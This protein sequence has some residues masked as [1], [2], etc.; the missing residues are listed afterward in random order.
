MA[1][2]SRARRGAGTRSGSTSGVQ[3]VGLAALRKEL[4]KLEDPRTWSKALAA[5]HREVAQDVAAEARSN[6]SSMGGAF[7]HFAPAIRGYGS[8]QAARV[9]L[10]DPNSY[11]TFWGA[12][13]QWTGWNVQ[14]E[15]R[16][17]NHPDWVGNS[18]DVAVRGQGPYALNDA[19][20]DR[21]EQSIQTLSEGIDAILRDAFPN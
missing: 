9:G 18:W 13:Q 10:R 5:V 16:R 19:A 1:A 8:V 20:A 4:R 6:A 11:A 15:G 7:R 17:P 14:S 12:K 3:I 21:S 2:P